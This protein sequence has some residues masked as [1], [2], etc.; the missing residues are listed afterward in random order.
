[1]K[2]NDPQEGVAYV[3]YVTEQSKNTPITVTWKYPDE[4]TEVI[5]YDLSGL[6][7]KKADNA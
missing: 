7:L 5:K 6:T 4:S 1:M 3:Y 2:G